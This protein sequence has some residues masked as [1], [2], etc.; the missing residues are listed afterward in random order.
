M[1]N[2]GVVRRV[3]LEADGEDIVAI[4]TANVKVFGACLI[5]LEVQGGQLEFRDML[6]PQQGKAIEFIARLRELGEFGDSSPR[7]MFNCAAKHHGGKHGFFME[8]QG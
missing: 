4:V 7:R 5:V 6:G 1:G 2:T 8:Q 3:G